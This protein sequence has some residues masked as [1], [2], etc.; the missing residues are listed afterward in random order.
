MDTSKVST[1]LDLTEMYFNENKHYVPLFEGFCK[2]H[3]VDNKEITA[4]ISGCPVSLKLATTPDSI[5][6][7]YMG[8]L[9]PKDNN[10]MMFVHPNDEVLNY[11][12][13]NVNYPLD[14]LFFDSNMKLVKHI[15][16]DACGDL[17]DSDLPKYSSD[18]Q[19]RFAVELR[20]G[21]CKDNNISNNSRL[22]I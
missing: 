3:Q 17:D 19:A 16:M 15:T 6:K 20:G 12:M 2:Q 1:F 13:K 10:G 8:K 5:S 18:K 7:G 4:S 21:W 9:E 11:W 22:K 14:I